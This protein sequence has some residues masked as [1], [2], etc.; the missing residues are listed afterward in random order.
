MFGYGNQCIGAGVSQQVLITVWVFLLNCFGK[1][2]R[3]DVFITIGLLLLSQ[4][5][6]LFFD[7]HGCGHGINGFY[8]QRTR[9]RRQFGDRVPVSFS[10][11]VDRRNFADAVALGLTPITVCSDLLKPGGY[12][13]LQGYHAEL[14]RRMTEVSVACVPDFV[15]QAYG[16]AEPALAD[17]GGDHA[18]PRRALREGG[19]LRA[20]AGD[21][22]YERWVSAARLRNSGIYASRVIAAQLETDK[23]LQAL[24]DNVAA[25]VKNAHP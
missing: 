11:G 13:R 2:L 24:M 12:G 19:C 3:G 20:A 8:Q 15:L 4:D 5:L 1:R 21:E 16:Q 23:E 7:L 9:F 14:K 17:L 18:A 25:K 6:F 22:L 10:A